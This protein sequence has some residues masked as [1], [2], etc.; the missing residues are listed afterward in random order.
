MSGEPNY[1]VSYYARRYASSEVERGQLVVPADNDTRSYLPATDANVAGRRAEAISLD[2]VESGAPGTI[3]LQQTGTI[4]AALSGLGEAVSGSWCRRSSDGY[5]ERCTPAEGDDIVGYA[6]TDGRVHLTFGFLT[7]E[8]LYGSETGGDLVRSDGTTID[9]VVG[10]N[11]TEL[12]TTDTPGTGEVWLKNGSKFR[13][14]KPVPPGWFDVTNDYGGTG[15]AAGD[16]TTDDTA[17]INATIAAANTAGLGIVY[18]PQ[19]TYKVTAQLTTP[20][21]HVCLKGPV[22]SSA[23]IKSYVVDTL[24]YLSEENDVNNEK[25]NG[26]ENL[27]FH[28]MVDSSPADFDT[29]AGAC[30]EIRGGGNHHIRSCLIRGFPIGICLDGTLSVRIYNTSVHKSDGVNG[31]LGYATNGKGIWLVDGVNRGRGWTIPEAINCNT[32]RHCLLGGNKQDIQVSGGYGN[33][34]DD[35]IFIGY[36][37][38]GVSAIRLDAPNGC[39]IIAMESEG[40]GGAG[41]RGILVT[42]GAYKITVERS[43]ISAEVPIRVDSPGSLSSCALLNNQLSPLGS[44]D[45]FETWAY[46]AVTALTAFG[47]WVSGGSNNLCNTE[48][49]GCLSYNR[50][51]YGLSINRTNAA[52]AVI[53]GMMHTDASTKPLILMEDRTGSR[54][55][56]TSESA[57][58]HSVRH[59][60][61]SSITGNSGGDLKVTEWAAKSAASGSTNI[62]LTSAITAD[63]VAQAVWTVV[64]HKGGALTT[65]G[66]W[67]YGQTVY[68]DGSGSLT[69][70]GSPVDMHPGGAVNTGGSF[71]APT[72]V[73]AGSNKLGVAV[74]G[75]AGAD[76]YVFVKLEVFAC[77]K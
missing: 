75:T 50:D 49:V 23:I 67:K 61:R 46:D 54:F 51:S 21:P 58:H 41:S 15:G 14:K 8:I 45:G 76:S 60:A 77:A 32:I 59:L 47:N 35:V 17:A 27:Q 7:P 1:S 65:Y 3:A 71:T 9:T 36:G 69:F 38:A 18:F 16:G 62:A 2:T 43:L 42:G 4:S 70:V 64:Q 30:I 40:Y 13:A 48:T 56:H 68:R 22:E 63:T 25:A 73:D 57:Q 66:S 12:E 39:N 20:A 37:L 28:C 53:H 6:D 5:I 26:V 10:I 24:L 74:S 29:D 44:H 11:G 19:G 34:I 52:Q 33:V 55:D 72:L 31:Y